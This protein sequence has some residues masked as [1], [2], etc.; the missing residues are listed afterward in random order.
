MELLPER[1]VR[2]AH[3][4]IPW[5]TREEHGVSI[6]K[7]RE[8]CQTE[9]TSGRPSE[10]EDFY[11]A[12][13]LC[14]DCGA[15]GARMIGWSKPTNEIEVKAAEEHGIE[16]LPFYETCPT[17]KGTGKADRSEWKGLLW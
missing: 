17:C 10:M 8:W 16:Q 5:H 3:G 14:Y 2:G 15:S 13:G 1:K 6:Q 11:A 4:L 12:H 7:M 9:K